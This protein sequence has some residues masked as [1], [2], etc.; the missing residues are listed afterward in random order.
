MPVQKCRKDGKD[1]YKY[2]LK[3]TCF[4]GP[5]AEERAKEQG[6]A[7][8]ISK[9]S[10]MEKVKAIFEKLKVSFDYDGVLSTDKG[11]EKAKEE[12]DLGNIV[13]IITARMESGDNSDLFSI[14]KELGI[15]KDRI[16]FTNHKDKWNEIK[17]LGINKHYD[18]NQEQINKINKNTDAK[19][20][21]L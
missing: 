5:D 3:G 11:K 15:S 13:Y 18:N 14:A 20:I 12:I 21:K 6:R 10:I 2:G 4:I 17:R 7:I 9:K 1:G 19:A 8:E 16:Y